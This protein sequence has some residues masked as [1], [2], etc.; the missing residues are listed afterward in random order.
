MKRPGLKFYLHRLNAYGQSY[1]QFVRY[2]QF[3]APL[4][5]SLK[6]HRRRLLQT[7]PRVGKK[8]LKLLEMSLIG[9]LQ[10][11][12]KGYYWIRSWKP[13][14][15]G[16]PPYLPQSL[17]DLL[18]LTDKSRARPSLIKKDFKHFIAF[19]LILV[20]LGFIVLFFWQVPVTFEA[21]IISRS[22]SFQTPP[23]TEQLLLNSLRSLPKLE[24]EGVQEIRLLGEFDSEAMREPLNEFDP[25]EIDLPYSHSKLILEDT[26]SSEGPGTAIAPT[27]PQTQVDE[28]AYDRQRHQ[29]SFR[30]IPPND[31]TSIPV[32]LSLGPTA[33]QLNLEGFES[34]QLRPQAEDEWGSPYQI[35]TFTWTPYSTELYLNLKGDTK[36]YIKLPDLE[37]T[38]YQDWFWGQLQVE[39]VRFT[40]VIQAEDV[41]DDRVR[42]TILEGQVNFLAE[43][44]PLESGQFLILP[45]R[46]TTIRR[47]PRIELHP[48]EPAGLRVRVQGKATQVAVGLDPEFPLRDLKSNFW[49]QW[50]TPELITVL[51]T[52]SSVM[53]G[54]LIPWLFCP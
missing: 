3:N 51:L 53:I 49:Q 37:A 11:M 43:S 23:N 38:D 52:V 50:L 35:E 30:L 26:A 17:D 45:Q 25:V 4:S 16:G 22:V 12:L 54:Y 39:D 24:F 48:E 9:L 15:S 42:S 33:L 28:F 34:P 6:R 29:L 41:R 10:I 20:C 31:E 5:R 19:S 14:Y 46:G 40:R 27:S 8:G 18:D 7:L 44:L 36:I 21:N 13:G 32:E 47:L 1:G 2:N